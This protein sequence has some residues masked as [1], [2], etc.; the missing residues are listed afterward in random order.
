MPDIPLLFDAFPRVTEEDWLARAHPD[1][2][3]RPDLV[4][5][6]SCG[7]EVPAYPFQGSSVGLESRNAGWKYA[8]PILQPDLGS[9]VKA[10]SEAARGQADS[11]L[12]RVGDSGLKHGDF[13][14]FLDRID[15]PAMAW[16]SDLPLSQ[17]MV[18][19][20]DLSGGATLDPVATALRTDS[21]PDYEGLSDA[22]NA[23]PGASIISVDLTAWDALGA[24]TCQLAAAAFGGI[25][26][27]L[28]RL[29]DPSSPI[30]ILLPVGTSFFE[31]IALVRAVRVGA[32]RVAEQ[33]GVDGNVSLLAIT[34]EDILAES[35]TDENL[36]RTTTS[37]MAA[38]L[39]GVDV[40]S[41]L[42]HDLKTGPSAR[43]SRL[44]RGISHLHRE[45]SYLDIVSDPGAGS[46]YI[47]QLTIG[48]GEQGWSTFRR[49]ES[50]GGLAVALEKGDPQAALSSSLRLRNEDFAT[51]RQVRVGT[52]KFQHAP[53]E[54][55]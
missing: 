38:I 55:S 2:E 16:T 44:A 40:L 6:S 27:W 30:T 5:T 41:I 1:P 43:G 34:S 7:L 14:A 18:L 46:R 35:G 4:W 47:E 19:G 24:N 11:C 8:E 10:A 39:G 32:K 51:G 22:M 50:M 36:L 15:L 12:V 29:P 48:I 53:E 21:Y 23:Y 20:T 37:S 49:W 17:V 28:Y 26:E 31:T 42:P 54:E 9:S 25:S 13:P 33:Y 45:E 52:N 3:S